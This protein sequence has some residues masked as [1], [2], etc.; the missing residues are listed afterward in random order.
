MLIFPE[1]QGRI[2]FH[3]GYANILCKIRIGFHINKT[4]KCDMLI[5]MQKAKIDHTCNL[6]LII[7]PFPKLLE[8]NIFPLHIECWVF[9]YI[10]IEGGRRKNST[11][12]REKRFRSHGSKFKSQLE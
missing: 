6:I 4:S 2:V 11:I 5:D 10:Y 1:I 12:I 9:Y 8:I 3:I 7:T